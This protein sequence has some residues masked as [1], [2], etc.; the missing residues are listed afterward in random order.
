MIT[1]AGRGYFRDPPLTQ[2]IKTN[3]PLGLVPSSVTL[4][5][6]VGDWMLE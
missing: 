1:A 6:P 3:V 5:A 2:A 4:R